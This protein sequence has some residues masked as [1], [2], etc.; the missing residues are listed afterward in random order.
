MISQCKANWLRA[1]HLI[2]CVATE[3]KELTRA[4]SGTSRLG[5][6]LRSGLPSEKAGP[7]YE[8][9]VQ[10]TEARIKQL[11]IRISKPM[12]TDKEF[13]EQPFHSSL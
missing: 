4:R 6:I 12:Q 5:F 7:Q 3:L 11:N 9:L 2:S 1:Q 8:A 10:E 13:H